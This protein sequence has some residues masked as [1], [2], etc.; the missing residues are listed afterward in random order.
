MTISGA[1]YCRISRDKTGAALGVERQESDCRKLAEQLGW[2]VRK[3]YVDNDISASAYT[4]RR[5]PEYEALLVDIASGAVNGVIAWHPDR[6]HRR[7]TELETYIDLSEK[8]GV[9]TH[10]VQSGRWDLST[11][12]GRLNARVVGGFATYESEHRSARVTAANA[13]RAA[14]GGWHGGRRA[15]GWEPDGMTPRETEAA[16]LL[17]AAEQIASGVSLRAVVADLNARKVPTTNGRRP[18]DSSTLRESLISPRHAGLA[19]YKGEIVG[20]ASWP[21]ILPMELWQN[22][23]RTLTDPAR[24]TNAGRSGTVKWLGSGIY[25]CGV[26]G[27]AEHMRARVTT[28]GR[29]RYRCGNRVK[30]NPVEHVGRDAV[31]LD[32]LV[33]M[34]I[35]AR[36]SDPAVLARLT[37]APDTLM[38]VPALRDELSQARVRLSEAADLF[39]SGAI[40]GSQLATITASLHN[41]IDMVEA[42]LATGVVASPL[43]VFKPG[44]DVATVWYGPGGPGGDRSG[45]LP[46]GTRREVL[47]LLCDVVINPAVP[48]PF[49]PEY[50]DI[51]WRK[52]TA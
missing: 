41:R 48:G 31:L 29:K 25:R 34:A 5:R 7:P 36:L 52:S 38:D 32:R 33:E 26:C 44:E 6:L 8:H 10:T 40:S 50:I 22:V 24:R 17:K 46:L 42:E 51:N 11:P 21:A 37:A 27:S 20:E 15:Y 47:R 14:R 3:V 23:H 13:Q 30:G 19:T 49:R 18:W 35:V 39:A 4:K 2:D 43:A 28:D 1:V 16:E 12:A 9:Q 45:G